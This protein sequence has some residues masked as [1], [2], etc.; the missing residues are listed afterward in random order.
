MPIKQ[1]EN[2]LINQPPIN[3]PPL[4]QPTIIITPEDSDDDMSSPA[5]TPYPTLSS[6]TYQTWVEQLAGKIVQNEFTSYVDQP[7]W[8]DVLHQQAN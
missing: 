3:Q 5:P 7:F 6:A 4:P 8:V 2:Q 1:K